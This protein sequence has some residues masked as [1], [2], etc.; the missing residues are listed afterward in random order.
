MPSTIGAKLPKELYFGV[1]VTAPQE[2]TMLN[3]ILKMFMMILSVV[4]SFR[5]KN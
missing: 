5:N 1:S 2:A 4:L 3:S